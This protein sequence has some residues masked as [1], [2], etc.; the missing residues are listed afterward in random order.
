MAEEKIYEGENAIT[1]LCKVFKKIEFGTEFQVRFSGINGEEKHADY[2]SKISIAGFS[3]EYRKEHG[4][5]GEITRKNG[6]VS[7]FGDEQPDYCLIL[8]H[9]GK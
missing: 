3:E 5:L 4:K 1:F 6:S 7:L 2:R 8:E 9:V